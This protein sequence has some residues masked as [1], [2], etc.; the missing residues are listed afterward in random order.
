MKKQAILGSIQ[1]LRGLGAIAVVIY[2]ALSLHPFF[3]FRAGAAGVDLFFVISGAVMFLSI[4][5]ETS[6]LSFLWR[7]AIRVIPIYWIF[8]TLAVIY[9]HTRYPEVTFSKE[10]IIR[11]YL[12][13]PPPEG[14]VMPV[15]YP[16]WTLNYEV[17][18]YLILGASLLFRSA[19]I[20]ISICIIAVLGSVFSSN[21]ALG[22]LYYANQ[23][24]LEFAAG[25]MLGWVIKS[26]Y[27][28]EKTT[29]AILL[30]TSIAIFAIHNEFKPE[31][32]IAWGIPSVM[33]VMGA[34]A[35]ESST[36]IQNRMVQLLGSASYS[37]YLIH[38]LAIWGIDWVWPDER[39][40]LTVITAIIISITAGTAVY[41]WVENP[42]LRVMMKI[43]PK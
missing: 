8:T 33:M 16:G 19:S 3:N 27:R 23:V 30:T 2:H 18:F 26:G 38:A 21:P 5:P 4:R 6:A 13:A 37:I 17:F 32:V 40:I 28:P 11:S 14:F 9:F 12:F 36:V 43:K 15:L 29:G 25:L 7:R 34:M 1:A 39:G 35:F 31:G 22:S 42:L 20:C 41:L 10:H 24:I